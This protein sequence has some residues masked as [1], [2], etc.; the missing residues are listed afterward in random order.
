[1]PRR[2]VCARAIVL[3]I[4]PPDGG[5]GRLVVVECDLPHA[6]VGDSAAGDDRRAP[7]DRRGRRLVRAIGADRDDLHVRQL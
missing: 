1:L 4:G 3:A 7:W 5:R 2:A 6:A